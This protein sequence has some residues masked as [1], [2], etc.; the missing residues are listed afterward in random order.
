[1]NELLIWEEI[2]IAQ[3]FGAKSYIKYNGKCIFSSAW[4]FRALNGNYLK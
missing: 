2:P 3:I 4:L 1:M